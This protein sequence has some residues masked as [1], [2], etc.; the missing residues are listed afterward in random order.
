ML[1]R[2]P[3]EL[4]RK[5]LNDPNANTYG[6]RG[7]AQQGVDIVG[8]RNGDPDHYVGIQ[9]KLKKEDKKLTKRILRDEVKE[10]LAFKPSL[11]EY[12]VITTAAD[13]AEIQQYARELELEIKKE[14]SRLVSVQVWGWDTLQREIQK[15]PDVTKIF[16]P[17]FTPHSEAIQRGVGDISLGQQA[18]AEQVSDGFER[19]EFALSAESRGVPNVLDLDRMR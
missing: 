10:A 12:F 13:S 6:T 2:G 8:K 19:I 3:V 15:Y 4:F 11:K 17:D 9:C 1:E 7:N 18:L 16:Y 14:H 5:I